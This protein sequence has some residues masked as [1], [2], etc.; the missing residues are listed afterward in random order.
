M[1]IP[2][3]PT[4][5]I[6]TIIIMTTMPTCLRGIDCSSVIITRHITRSAGASITIRFS[7]GIPTMIRSGITI[8]MSGMDGTIHITRLTFI[9]AGLHGDTATMLITD[10]TGDIMDI[11]CIRGVPGDIRDTTLFTRIVT[12]PHAHLEPA[13]V[14]FGMERTDCLLPEEQPVTG[15]V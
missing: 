14:M 15:Q 12:V 2:E 1:T 9:S 3:L 10:G 7:C 13:A 11:I 8:I 6:P 4:G 5:T